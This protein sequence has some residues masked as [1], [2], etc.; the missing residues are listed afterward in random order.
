MRTGSEKMW[1]GLIERQIRS[2][3]RLLPYMLGKVAGGFTAVIGFTG[4]VIAITRRAD[5]SWPDIWPYLLSGIAGVFLFYISSRLAV[6]RVEVNDDKV[7]IPQ[8][9]K[10]AGILSWLLF[11]AA[12]LVFVL[13]TYY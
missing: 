1:M 9:T 6:K 12:A 10:K 4:A 11:L 2:E 8:E 7:M 13:F 3:I 5:P